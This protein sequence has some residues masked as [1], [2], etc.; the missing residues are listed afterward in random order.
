MQGDTGRYRERVL[1]L[2]AAEK[3]KRDLRD[4][5]K[6]HREHGSLL[7]AEGWERTHA[8]HVAKQARPH[9]RPSPS[10]N[11]SPSPRPHPSRSPSPHP[12]PSP[13]PS[14]S[15][16]HSPKLNPSPSPSPS[17]KPQP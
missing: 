13:S 14:H 2:Q 3:D 6:L 1:S 15:H 10:P 11:P 5:V 12:H 8:L 17:P 7:P 9:P 16:S 4:H